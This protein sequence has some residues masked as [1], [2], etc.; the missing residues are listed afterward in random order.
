MTRLFDVEIVI[1]I[2]KGVVVLGNK[3]YAFSKL[4]FIIF[5][6][7]SPVGFF[8]CCPHHHVQRLANTTGTWPHLFEVLS[9]PL[10]FVF[11]ASLL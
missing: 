2:Y 1:V 4:F 3:R 5:M 7:A 8:L 10:L 9:V 11:A 6:M